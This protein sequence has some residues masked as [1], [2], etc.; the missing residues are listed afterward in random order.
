MPKESSATATPT[1]EEEIL[2]EQ[3]SKD[4]EAKNADQASYKTFLAPNMKSLKKDCELGPRHL[5]IPDQNFQ[6]GTD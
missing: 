4:M 2:L 1:R 6:A 3:D 5:T